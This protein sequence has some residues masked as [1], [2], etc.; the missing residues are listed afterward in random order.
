MGDL[1]SKKVAIEAVS[2]DVMGGLNA[3]SILEGLPS[4]DQ[5]TAWKDRI[6]F[7]DEIVL[8][9]DGD[10]YWIDQ[11]CVYGDPDNYYEAWCREDVARLQQGGCTSKTV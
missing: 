2:K 9:T 5:W 6:P 3:E 7:C 4:V 10:E 11:A 8:V 1:I